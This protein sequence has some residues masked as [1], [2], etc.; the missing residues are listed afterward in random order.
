MRCLKCVLEVI[1]DIGKREANS[2][3]LPNILPVREGE[4]RPGRL[5]IASG[6]RPADVVPMT[7]AQQNA[8][9]SVSLS[10]GIFGTEKKLYRNDKMATQVQRTSVVTSV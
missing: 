3:Q 9:A 6:V 8:T 7:R 10:F 5:P 4:L 2:K 1:R